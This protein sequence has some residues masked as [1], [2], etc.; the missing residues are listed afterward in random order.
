MDKG[1]VRRVHQPD[2]GVV[3]RCCEA[4]PLDEI[5]WSFVEPVE[6]RHLRRRGGV[7]AEKHPD[8][9]LH[10]AH[11]VAADTDTLR[12]EGLV[13]H[14]RRDQGA[15]PAGVEAPAVIAAL[16]LVPVET[17]GAERHPTMRAGVV[18]RERRAG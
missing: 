9:S 17:T 15:L 12:R 1:P 4:Y 11:R 3:D 2:D 5:G 6:Q 14:K 10:L 18:Q 7:V 13:W 8:V 16:D